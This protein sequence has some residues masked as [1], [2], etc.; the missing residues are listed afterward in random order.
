MDTNCRDVSS[1]HCPTRQLQEC[2]PALSLLTR[3]TSGTG[4]QLTATDCTAPPS[5]PS[6]QASRIVPPPTRL[7]APASSATAFPQLLSGI[8]RLLSSSI[9]VT[10]FPLFHSATLLS[11][12]TGTAG[13]RHRL[14]RRCHLLLL[15]EPIFL[16]AKTA[17]STAPFNKRQSCHSNHSHATP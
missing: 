6:L 1:S 4:L 8:S 2:L 9:A 10:H 11:L 14:P 13:N 12:A 15:V 7:L 5:L 3:A 16:C 17:L